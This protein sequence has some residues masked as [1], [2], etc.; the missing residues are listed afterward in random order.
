M[1]Q[2][3]ALAPGELARLQAFLNTNDVEGGVDELA[4]PEDL[5]KWL[6]AKDF[7]AP[8]RLS[9]K[10]LDRMKRFRES[11]RD[12]V[13]ANNEEELDSRSVEGLNQIIRSAK[14]TPSFDSSGHLSFRSYSS[15]VDS[16]M[17]QM[18]V[19]I[20]EAMQEGTWH[21]LKACSENSCH[22]AFYDHS[23]N[24]SSTW[25][26]M[27]VCGNRAKARRFRQKRSGETA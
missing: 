23:K 16:A 11:L 15:G 1:S 21:R 19:I 17:G 3:R 26:S 27:R 4:S 14:L 12:L 6:A 5:S 25:C 7:E 8:K 18:M 20:F 9:A 24:Q 13:L 10:D 2:T 22:W